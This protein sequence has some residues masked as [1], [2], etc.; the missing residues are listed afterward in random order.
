MA[1][2]ETIW[3]PVRGCTP[4]SPGCERCYAARIGR[5]FSGVGEPFEGLVEP[6][7]GG[8]RFTGVVRV[9]EQ[10]LEEPLRWGRSPRLVA[11]GTLGDLFHEQLPDAVIE[12]V[13][14]VMRQADR[15]TFRVLTKRARRMQRL[16][17]RV[18]GGDETKPPPNVWLG[19]SVE[20]QRNAD[21]RVPPLR[22]TPAA[23]RYIVCE[24]LLDRV[25]LSAHLVRY[26]VERSSR[27]VHWV[28]A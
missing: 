25:D 10:L 5:H 9:D 4:V 26:I 8:A 14:D 22:H 24:P 16:V 6:H 13:L 21:A 17:T 27:L 18:Y 28:V 19:V 15:H 2:I 20:D 1:A 7:G 11:V 3:N 12:R 23:V